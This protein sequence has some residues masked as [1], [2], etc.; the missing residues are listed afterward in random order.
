MKRKPIL[1]LLVV[2]ISLLA[3]GLWPMSSKNFE[4]TFDKEKIAAKKEY[5]NSIVADTGNKPNIVIIVA[6]DLGKTDISLYGKPPIQTPNI[7]SIRL[8]S[9]N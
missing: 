2:L 5:L 7:D 6:D 8:R 9:I 1:F 3:Y 4:I